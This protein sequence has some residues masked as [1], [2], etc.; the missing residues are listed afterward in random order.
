MTTAI[1]YEIGLP[2]L[3]STPPPCPLPVNDKEGGVRIAV[4]ET[5]GLRFMDV[6]G[7]Y[8]V[9]KWPCCRCSPSM[10]VE[11]E[12]EVVVLSYIDGGRGFDDA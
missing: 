10:M 12:G 6:W 2:G 1:G 3:L 8:K 9:W 4:G 5:I 7:C 11:G